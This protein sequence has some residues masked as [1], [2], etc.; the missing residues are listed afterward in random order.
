MIYGCNI[1]GP[2][3]LVLPFAIFLYLMHIYLFFIHQEINSETQQICSV[4]IL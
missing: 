1:T 3:G 2:D 4:E